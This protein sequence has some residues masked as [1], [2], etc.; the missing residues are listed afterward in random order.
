MGAASRNTCRLARVLQVTRTRNTAGGIVTGLSVPAALCVCAPDKLTSSCPTHSTSTHNTLGSNWTR[1]QRSLDDPLNDSLLI[2]EIFGIFPATHTDRSC[3]FF[4]AN[5]TT[6]SIPVEGNHSVLSFHNRKSSVGYNIDVMIL[7]GR[8]M[9]F[10]ED[11]SVVGKGKN[12]DEN[13]SKWSSE[14]RL[15]PAFRPMT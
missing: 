6:L 3:F 11:Q 2:A 15:S 5:I 13:K 12:T 7:L 14:R 1:A 4:F 10:Y 8:W 9:G